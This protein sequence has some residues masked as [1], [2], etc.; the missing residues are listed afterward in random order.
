MPFLRKLLSLGGCARLP[1]DKEGNEKNEASDNISD[2]GSSFVENGFSAQFCESS[3]AQ[4]AWRSPRFGRMVRDSPRLVT[5]AISKMVSNSMMTNEGDDE[6]ESSEI[7]NDVRSTLET[8]TLIVHQDSD[9]FSEINYVPGAWRSPSV[10]RR[11][12]ERVRDS[13]R[14]L[15]KV[16]SKMTSPLVSRRKNE[17]EIFMIT[18]D[19]VHSSGRV[20]RGEGRA[21]AW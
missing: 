2:D 18:L 20:G 10:G 8:N 7:V 11:V 4:G 16:M 9:R 15:R 14:M 12:L 21:D 3:N 5:K 17:D 1:E 19:V 13:P 6:Q